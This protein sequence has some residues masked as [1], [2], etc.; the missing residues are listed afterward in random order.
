[1]PGYKRVGG[2]I[3]IL[4]F[5]AALVL[6]FTRG[7][8][9]SVSLSIIIM[10]FFL[11][12]RKLKIGL[13]S[14]T[15]LFAI[16]AVL[17]VTVGH[18]P[19]FDR[20]FSQDIATLNGR[21]YLWQAILDRFD[22]TQLLGNGLQASDTLLAG[23]GVG[24]IATAPSNLFVGTLYNHGIIGLILLSC[25]FISLLASLIVGMRKASGEH[26]MLFA[27]AIAVFVNLLLQSIESSDF[28]AQAIGIYFWII[29]VLPFALCWSST[30]QPGEFSSESFDDD[31]STELRMAAIQR[32]QHKSSTKQPGEFGSESF[33]DDESTELRMVAIQPEQH[34]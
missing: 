27:A 29:M 16:I 14:S 9:I 15:L 24:S 7:A 17:F 8:F 19:I 28:W 20:F 18:V 30:K 21:T 1:L 4:V 2:L 22:P 12:S 13:L 3:L 23:L 33:D 31:E 6:T 25:V 10:I 32:G 34:N 26:R 11:P 5:L